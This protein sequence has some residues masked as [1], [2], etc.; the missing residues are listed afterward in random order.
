MNIY[1]YR[2]GQPPCRFTLV[3]PQA[4]A[5]HDLGIVSKWWWCGTFEEPKGKEIK[6]IHICIPSNIK[7]QMKFA[8]LLSLGELG[9]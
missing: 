9:Y 3:T 2:K 5:Q 8:I 7:T 6:V 4:C 1:P